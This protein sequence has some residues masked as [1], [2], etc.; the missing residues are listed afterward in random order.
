[1]HYCRWRSTGDPLKTKTGAWDETAGERLTRRSVVDPS[2]CIVWIGPVDKDGYGKFTKKGFPDRAHQ[3]AYVVA[4][5]PIPEGH[6]VRHTCDNPPCINPNHLIDGTFADNASD[7]VQRERFNRES[8]RYNLVR[9]SMN[10]AREIRAKHSQGTSR[11]ALAAEYGVGAD[12]ISRV[13]HHQN[14]KETA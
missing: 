5:G 7:R 1:M 11:I 4:N 14:W 3:A 6:I 12:Q 8:S 2:G 10:L 13:I 9:L